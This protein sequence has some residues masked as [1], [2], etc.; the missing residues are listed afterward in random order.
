MVIHIEMPLGWAINAIGPMKAGVKPLWGIGR[1]HLTCKHITKFVVIGAGV[2]LGA[3]T[4][5]AFGPQVILAPC[6]RRLLG[7]PLGV[8]DPPLEALQREA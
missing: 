1:A 4:A 5:I 2:M 8:M 7:L 3:T 6:E